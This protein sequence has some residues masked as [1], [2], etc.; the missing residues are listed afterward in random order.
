MFS[1][2][3]SLALWLSLLA[4]SNATQAATSLFF[5][6]YT[7]YENNDALEIF[8]ASSQSIDLSGYQIAIYP[9]G[10]LSPNDPFDLQG[11]IPAGETLVYSHHFADSEL[12][13]RNTEEQRS[14]RIA[15]DGNDAIALRKKVGNGNTF[16]IIDFIGQLGQNQVWGTGNTQT[17][18]HTLRRK[19]HIEQGDCNPNDSFD[20][21]AEW[22]GFPSNTFYHFGE[23]QIIPLAA[24]TPPQAHAGDNQAVFSNTAVQLN[25]SLSADQESPIINYL[26]EQLSGTLV[27]LDINNSNQASKPKFTAPSITQTEILQF[28]LTVTDSLGA[29]HS[30]VVDIQVTPPSTCNTTPHFISSIQGEA[31]QS[32]FIGQTVTVKGIVTKKLDSFHGFVIQEEAHEQDALATTS[33]A[34]FINHPA[35]LSDINEGDLVAITGEV[36]EENTLTQLQ[37]ITQYEICS[38]NHTTAATNIQL[39]LTTTEREAY[40]S[41]LVS[42]T[43]PLTITDIDQLTRFGQFTVSSNGRL[44]K[45]TQVEEKGTK[46]QAITSSNQNHQ[47]VIDDG[48]ADNNINQQYPTPLNLLGFGTVTYQHP[49]RAGFTL[50]QATGILHYASNQL[51]P[52]QSQPQYQLIPSQSLT[53]TASNPRSQY[54]TPPQLE[55]NITVAS[56]SVNN[57]FTTLNTGAYQC[58]PTTNQACLGAT[59]LASFMRQKDKLLNTI[60]QLDTDI[61]A[62]MGIE[63]HPTDHTLND[64][65]NG[66]NILLGE[67]RYRAINTGT[68]G[69]KATKSALLYKANTVTPIDE[70]NILGY[71]EDVTHPSL[72]QT[73]VPKNKPHTDNQFTVAVNHFASKQSSCDHLNDADLLDGQGACNFT[74]TMSANGLLMKL[75]EL[76]KPKPLVIGMLNAFSQE[77]PIWALTESGYIDLTTQHINP[78]KHYS[79]Q[80][81]G[82]WGVLNHALASPNLTKHI[83]DTKFWHINSDE[84]SGFNYVSTHTPYQNNGAFRVSSHDPLL[85]GLS[86]TKEKQQVV[87]PQTGEP[88]P[89]PHTPPATPEPPTPPVLSSGGG[90]LSWVLLGL[91]GLILRRYQTS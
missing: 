63:N 15:F 73:F 50:N 24:N 30:D 85:V 46:A 11:I 38:H 43:Q 18:E 13:Q 26:W 37:N 42:I 4:F 84:P 60:I 20:P 77:D 58:G 7:E 40:E 64:L 52:Q 3:K 54:V 1:Y 83:T 2:K 61:L 5:T 80:D 32:T 65:I 29:T 62:L 69:S 49:I 35:M 14:S 23:H 48:Q 74:R 59:N 57:Y 91:L 17:R 45:G 89:E 28:R 56:L 22:L 90:S 66:L 88:D 10:T 51:S 79:S 44:F 31:E 71:N 86:L 75:L 36:S 8:N 16:E 47:L 53:L 25:G 68:I 76:N 55:G 82:E 12:L 81:S 21:D 34:L 87:A 39:P 33:E 9:N 19:A 70:V 72:I 6:E 41:M 27:T 78:A 67:S